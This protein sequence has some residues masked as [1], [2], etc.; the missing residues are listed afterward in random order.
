MLRRNILL[1]LVVV[2]LIGCKTVKQKGESEIMEDATPPSN[3]QP[4]FLS[5]I[6][7]YD[8]NNLKYPSAVVSGIDARQPNLIKV[9]MHFVDMDSVFLTGAVEQNIKDKICFFVDSSAAGE[10]PITNYS[11]KEVAN[12]D[13]QPYSIA[14]VM[15]H[16]GSMGE[17]RAL[18][19]QNAAEKFINSKRDM[20]FVSLIKYDQK[21]VAESPLLNNKQELLAKL[22]KTGLKNYGGMTAISSSLDAAIKVLDSANS[23][24]SKAIIIFTDGW[25]N[26]STIP[27]DSVI[28]KALATNTM[29]CAVDFGENINP[30]FMKHIA[31]STGGTYH[32]IYKTD[33]FQPVFDDLYLRL[34]NYYL[35]EYKTKDYGPHIIKVRVCLPKD[36]L[37]AQGN[38][39]NTP[40]VGAICLLNIYFDF[41]KAT[42]QKESEDAIESVNSLL[43]YYPNMRIEVR[44][45]T[46]SVNGNKD[47]DYNLKLSQKRADAVKNALVK[48]GIPLSRVSSIGFGEKKPVADNS[49]DKG[50]AKNRRTEFVIIS[51]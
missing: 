50:R 46:D 17:W 6:A 27:A 51:K 48:K 12:N 5:Q 23:Y 1:A 35:V 2:L 3:Y 39:D 19:V 8:E 38:F 31:E 20:D 28:A 21:V 47:P 15:D 25:D 44:G 40:N 29:I 34:N 7:S 22:Q 16:S 24:H 9:R 4:V 32:H 49:T 14:L 10:K 33:E 37:K 36:T 26:S 45:H 42:I 41:D 11:I 43:N 18:A 30:N 13:D